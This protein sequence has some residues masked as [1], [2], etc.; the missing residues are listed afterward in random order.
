MVAP[1]ET[2]LEDGEGTVGVLDSVVAPLGINVAV[3]ALVPDVS[4]FP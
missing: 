2:P 1:F 3:L 4:A